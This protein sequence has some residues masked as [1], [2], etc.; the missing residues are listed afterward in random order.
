[1]EKLWTELASTDATQAYRA[2]WAFRRM[3]AQA[4]PFLARRLPAAVRPNVAKLE[5]WV[6]D[7][8]SEHFGVRE[9]ANR[10]LA[11]LG[12][13]A[14]PALRKAVRG[15][16]PLEVRQRVQTL[17]DKLPTPMTLPEP[18]R[19]VRTVEILEYM[20]RDDAKRLLQ[21]YAAGAP[22][23]R[24]TQDAGE[25]LA[26]L[27]KRQQTPIPV[28]IGKRPLTDLYG[29]PLPAGAVARLGTTRFRLR[30]V[31]TWFRDEFAFLPG[32]KTL[33][34]VGGTEV[35]VW[36]VATRRVVREFSTHPLTIEDSALTP[37]RKRLVVAGYSQAPAPEEPRTAETR[38]LDLASGKLHTFPDKNP[39]RDL[40]VSADG[41]LLFSFDLFGTL[42]VEE[43]ASGKRVFKQKVASSFDRIAVSPDGIHVAI[44]PHGRGSSDL[45]L[46]K[47]RNERPH[48]L[49]AFE[50]GYG[51]CEVSFSPDGRL[52]AA[53]GQF[54]GTLRVWQVPGGRLLYQRDC[55]QR[56]YVFSGRPV[57][58]PNGK[59]LIV[60]ARDPATG[61]RKIEI[62]EPATGRSQGVMAGSWQLAVASD[63]RHFAFI[64]GQAVRI[65]DLVSRKELS[66]KDDGHECE[67]WQ[68][69]ASSGDSLVTTGTDNTVRVWNTATGTQRHVFPVNNWVL[70]LALSPDGKLLAASVFDGHVHVWDTSSGRE[71]YRLAGHGGRDAGGRRAL[72]F[73][74]TG[75]R[76]LSWGED[77][78]LRGWNMK[79]GRALFEHAIRPEGV[80]ISDDFPNNPSD[81]V[82]ILES[83][84]TPD[85]NTLLVEVD[86]TVHFFDT[87][88]GKQVRKLPC[89]TGSFAMTISPEG[90]QI[91]TYAGGTDEMKSHPIAL[92]QLTAGKRLW[93]IAVPGSDTCSAVF[94]PDGRMV[95]TSA[96]ERQDEIHIYEMASAE[97]RH[98]IRGI[99]GGVRSLAF[100]PDGRR[101]ASGLSDCTVVIWDL[102]AGR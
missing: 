74:S 46:W 16:L 50:F 78:Y 94:S 45:C 90:R 5:G 102:A 70:A 10:E 83:A 52:L 91:L 82:L 8:N 101:L 63:S 13:L 89:E 14:E 35:R 32:D 37:D 19:A 43:L 40:A 7:L 23:S 29:D 38:V 3:P 25:A 34:T 88:T 71:I 62:L 60:P 80:N 93:E 49:R 75:Q 98:I 26:R 18:L 72:S 56:D 86:G 65:V 66:P 57:F 27:E 11:H 99:P 31:S 79:N 55:A 47:W 73:S 9:R 58:T 87:L 17:L 6:R 21:I 69:L 97:R 30:E 33:L 44:A 12:G 77:L 4:V 92:W 1:M 100:L 39:R 2:I 51:E 84:I 96:G 67:P 64:S 61:R 36:D 95:A 28:V 76:L 48:L 59:M 24:L 22:G 81:G 85:G 41:K 68:M 15:S 20:D 54:D 53:V 42:Y